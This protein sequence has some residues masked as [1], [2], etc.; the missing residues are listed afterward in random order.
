MSHVL[1]NSVWHALTGPQA[2]VALGHGRARHFPRD[3]AEVKS[4]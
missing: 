4:E 1:D 2:D 3:M